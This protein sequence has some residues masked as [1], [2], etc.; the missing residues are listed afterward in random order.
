M[1]KLLVISAVLAGFSFSVLAD[2]TVVRERSDNDGVAIK[3]PVPGVVV[4]DKSEDCATKTVHRED[5]AGDS[6]TIKKT[7]CD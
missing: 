2:E 3:V 1:K 7:N 6:T 5:G 4:K